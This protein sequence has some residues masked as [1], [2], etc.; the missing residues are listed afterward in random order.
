MVT[1]LEEIILSLIIILFT[2]YELLFIKMTLGIMISTTK[3]SII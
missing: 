2:K 3:W 1:K